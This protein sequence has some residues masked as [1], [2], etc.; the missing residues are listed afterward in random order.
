MPRDGDYIQAHEGFSMTS[1]PSLFDEALRRNWRARAA[2]AGAGASDTALE[3]LHEH[4]AQSLVERLEPINRR[5]ASVLVAA[6]ATGAYGAALKQRPDLERLVQLEEAEALAERLRADAAACETVLTGAL[7]AGLPDADAL[8]PASFDLVLIGFDLHARND[9]VA[10]LSQARLLLKPDGLLLVAMA[11]GETLAELRAS[12]AEAEIEITGGLSPR[13]APMGEIRDLGGLLQ[14]AGFALPV[15]DSEKLELW[16]Q[17]PLHL[18]Q[19]IRAV[20]EG[21]ALSQR[22]RQFLRRD[23]LGRGLALYQERFSRPDGKTRATLEIVTLTGWAPAASQ[24]QP[25]R[26]GSAK[27]RLADALGTEERSTDEKA[28]PRR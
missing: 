17:S 6:A 21:N 18:M 27:A 23:V 9:P 20:G 14:R 1:P 25:L 2:R 10:A 24:Q 19:E 15:A 16:H 4:V 7:G 3:A 22:R 28:T 12:L 5:F 26:P 13:V 8:A 11:G